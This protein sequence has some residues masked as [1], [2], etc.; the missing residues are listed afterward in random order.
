VSR[1]YY[2]DSVVL[3]DFDGV[4]FDTRLE[5]FAL[6]AEVA[7][8]YTEYRSDVEADEFFRFRRY[9]RDAWQFNL[10]F[11]SETRLKDCSFIQAATPTDK[12]YLFA[13]RLF[14]VRAEM[15][16]DQSLKKFI[17]PYRFFEEISDWLKRS[18]ESFRIL[19]TRNE[20]SIVGILKGNGITDV[21]VYGQSMVKA[22]GS[23]L[24]VVQET[25]ILKSFSHVTYIDDMQ[26]HLD[27]FK[28]TT[29]RCL[30]AGWGYDQPGP[31]A[32]DC[33]RAICLIS[34]LFS[35]EKTSLVC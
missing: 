32:I 18:S 26:S 22:H 35:S 13:S 19:S 21:E 14:E 25:G 28:S 7:R 11:S 34:E 33:E 20:E 27:P 5:V 17:R 23:K 30:Q 2:Q 3:L 16:D 4:L 31:S 12:D 24:Q 29:V 1:Q 8:R 6:C 9:L 10:L 15:Y